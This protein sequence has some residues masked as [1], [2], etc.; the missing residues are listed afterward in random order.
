MVGIAEDVL[1]VPSELAEL[2]RQ[3]LLLKLQFPGKVQFHVVKL[4]PS[5]LV[6]PAIRAMTYCVVVRCV[7]RVEFE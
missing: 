3:P 1:P 6:F 2:G 5:Q 4:K 7:V